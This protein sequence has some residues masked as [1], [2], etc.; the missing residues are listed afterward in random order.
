M[1][2]RSTCQPLLDLRTLVRCV[3]VDDQVN[4]Q[5]IRHVLV[6]V[7]EK[8]QKL[9]MAMTFFALCDYFAAGHVQGGEQGGCTMSD[10][11]MRYAFGIAQSQR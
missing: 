3:I 1:V 2:A 10:V 6:D 4:L 7:F 8:T 9:L 5:V 11:V